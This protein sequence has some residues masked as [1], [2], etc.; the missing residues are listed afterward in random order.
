MSIAEEFQAAL[1]SA[2][3]SLERQME[4]VGL[5]LAVVTNVSDPDKLNRVKCVPVEN[6]LDGDTVGDYFITKVRHQFG[7]G[8]YLTQF[9]VKGA[10]D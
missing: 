3:Y 2:G 4:R 1:N 7:S 8:G 9:E 6:D 5:A 10:K